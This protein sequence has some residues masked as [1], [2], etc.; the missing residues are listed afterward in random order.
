MCVLLLYACNKRTSLERDTEPKCN[1]I[2]SMLYKLWSSVD[3]DTKIES[4][5]SNSTK[6][7]SSFELFK[8]INPSILNILR[9]MRPAQLEY[10]KTVKPGDLRFLKYLNPADI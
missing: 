9:T 5:L 3:S 1:T 7:A 10:F 6:A 8:T 4:R 2:F